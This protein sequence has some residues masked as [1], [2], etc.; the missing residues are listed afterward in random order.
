MALIIT[1][2]EMLRNF[3]PNV[4]STID[5]ELPIYDKL[6]PYLNIAESWLIQNITGQDVLNK[7]AS[8]TGDDRFM[9]VAMAVVSHA[10]ALAVPS[11]DLVL[12]PN[13]FGIVSN[14]NVVPASK[15]RVER[16]IRSLYELRSQCLIVLLNKL[17]SNSDWHSSPQCDMLAK[18]I[19][20]D[21]N[22]VTVCDT[23]N[24]AEADIWAAFIALR[25]RAMPI[26]CEI[27]NGWIS[28]QL[29]ARLCRCEATA[30]H[31]DGISWLI[32]AIRG[33][34]CARLTSGEMNTP[35]LD[36]IVSYIR[37]YP[38]L[39]PEWHQS[40]TAKLF[41]PTTFKNEKKSSGY[42]F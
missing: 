42:F 40:A 1:D 20:Q 30:T 25:H 26:E 23:S 38:D 12:T 33:V 39:F 28:P 18:S 19:L 29:M 15:D 2:D 11:L 16:L 22:L 17:R 31:S 5:D 14:K 3:I 7:I 32:S 21:P 10:Y 4:F 8:D 27:A 41:S 13:G 9:T 36:D 34:V 6:L 35:L 37:S 24:H